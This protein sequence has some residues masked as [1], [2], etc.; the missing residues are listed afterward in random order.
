MIY[1]AQ[2]NFIFLKTTKTAGTSFEIVLSKYADPADIVTPISDEDEKTRQ[3]LGFPGPQNYLE[4]PGLLQRLGFRKA[5]KTFYNHIPAA[6]VRAKLGAELFGRALKVSI[7][8]NPYDLAVSRYFW[9]HR[10][11]DDTSPAH[12]RAWL[13]SHPPVLKKNRLITHI[14]GQSAVDL[15]IRFEAFE[16]G[17]TRF[18]AQTGLPG[19]LYAEFDAMRAKGQYRPKRAKT[20]DMFEGFAEGKAVIAQMF[21]EDIERYHYSCP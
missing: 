8:R 5:S 9:S 11:Q 17:I 15:M 18:A 4:P 1:S 2:H 20:A 21:A 3:A 12:F 10:R 19:T 14:D 16:E 6:E 7:V 13:L